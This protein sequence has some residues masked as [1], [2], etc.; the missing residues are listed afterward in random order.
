MRFNKFNIIVGIQLILILFS[1]YLISMALLEERLKITVLYLGVVILIQAYILFRT[2]SRNNRNLL[3]IFQTMKSNDLSSKLPA[4]TAG[5]PFKELSYL[6]NEF[7]EEMGQLRIEKEKEYN[8]FRNTIKHVNTG[9]VA[10]Q[11]NGQVKLVNDALFKIFQIKSLN[12]ITSLNNFY[13]GFED[14]LKELKPGESQ[15]IKFFLDENQLQLSLIC[16]EFVIDKLHLKLISFH[17]MK[18]EFSREEAE[19]WHKLISVLRHEIMNSVGPIT[20]LVSTL[21]EEYEERNKVDP[22]SRLV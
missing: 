22:D 6:L 18:S 20:S 4:S 10:F 11:D 17:D 1:N 15:T 5:K 13:N 16:S 14:L 19:T 8:F 12:N 3:N 21:V 7:I 9:L 2:I